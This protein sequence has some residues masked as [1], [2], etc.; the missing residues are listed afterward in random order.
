MNSADALRR[1]W[2]SKDPPRT[3]GGARDLSFPGSGTAFLRRSRQTAAHC[4]SLN[5]LRGEIT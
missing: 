5:D 3:D 4:G 2:R 1:R